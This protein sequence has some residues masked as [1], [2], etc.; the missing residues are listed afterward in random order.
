MVT[1]QAVAKAWVR[2]KSRT[3]LPLPGVL[4][5]FQGPL[6]SPQHPRSE[7]EYSGDRL[8]VGGSPIERPQGVFYFCSKHG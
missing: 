1:S 3:P 6:L 7:D 8:G 2:L 5:W 4:I